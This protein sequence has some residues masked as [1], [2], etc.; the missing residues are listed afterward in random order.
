MSIILNIG[1]AQATAYHG[2]YLKLVQLDDIIKI[3]QELQGAVWYFVKLCKEAK[4]AKMGASQVINLLRIANNYLPSVEHRCEELQKENNFLAI[5]ATKYRQIQNL[6][7]QIR[8]TGKS[9][10]AGRHEKE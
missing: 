8:D 4:A 10:D 6:N 1:Q 3:Y 2:E 5:I 9:L 7:S